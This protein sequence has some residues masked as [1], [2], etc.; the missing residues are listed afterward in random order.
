MIRSLP[1]LACLALAAC[2]S[3]P[4]APTVDG[5]R[6]V[7]INDAKTVLAI[8]QGKTHTAPTESRVFRYHFPSGGTRL[9]LS[10]H[11]LADLMPLARQAE[12]IEV[13]ARTDAPAPD[14]NDLITAK[15]RAESARD[16]LVANGVNR[17]KITLNY[18]SGGDYLDNN[19]TPEG[20]ALN[21]RVEI[22]VFTQK[23]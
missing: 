22:E 19:M 21:R 2:S 5:S 14:N 12:R 20:R 4:D 6:R 13:R 8:Q 11:D 15:R 7:P 10:A 17:G 3:A 18:L 23:I 1:F 9:K 16:I